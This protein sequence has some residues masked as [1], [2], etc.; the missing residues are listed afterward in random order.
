MIEK[1]VASLRKDK[2]LRIGY[3][4]NIAMPFYDAHK[5]Y[6][7]MTG[8]RC[9]AR[10]DLWIISNAAAEYFV[11]LLSSQLPK[12]KGESSYAMAHSIGHYLKKSEK[13]Y[14]E[15]K[16]LSKKTTEQALKTI[17]KQI[18]IV[19][20]KQGITNKG[21]LVVI[22]TGKGGSPVAKATKQLATQDITRVRAKNPNKTK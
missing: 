10:K 15:A 19:K 13:E 14:L 22:G 4:S 16:K 2:G 5:M 11:D 7:A 18:K 21:P 6:Q 1:L 17:R 3:V 12:T 20:T 9:S 8:R